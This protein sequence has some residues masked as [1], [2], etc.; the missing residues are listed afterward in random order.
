MRKNKDPNIDLLDFIFKLHQITQAINKI[1][2]SVLIGAMDCKLTP[3][4]EDEK[5]DA[6]YSPRF[7]LTPRVFIYTFLRYI[8][9]NYH[10]RKSICNTSS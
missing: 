5:F 8:P 2:K 3:M 6:L 7:R 4:T 1:N 10:N 9:T